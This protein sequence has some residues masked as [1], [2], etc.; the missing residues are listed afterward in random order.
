MTMTERGIYH[1]LMVLCWQYG[2]I[3]WDK[4]LLAKRLGIDPRVT[5]RWMEKYTFLTSTL[6]D[7]SSKMGVSLPTPCTKVTLPKLQEFAETLARN[8]PADS[9]RRGEDIQEDIRPEDT[10]LSTPLPKEDS[11]SSFPSTTKANTT[12]SSPKLV[13]SLPLVS[14]KGDRRSYSE[15]EVDQ[16]L[17]YHFHFRKDSFW[18]KKVTDEM[19]LRRNID[20]MYAQMVEKVGADW[21]PDSPIPTRIATA[22]TPAD[23][24]KDKNNCPTCGLNLFHCNC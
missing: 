3:P 19:A 21:N 1:E 10:Q 8:A 15:S 5:A 16:V 12:R 7:S 18:K 24:V 4:N 22:K 11:L 9:Q 14:E 23:P 13:F 2:S 17:R 20:T 6:H